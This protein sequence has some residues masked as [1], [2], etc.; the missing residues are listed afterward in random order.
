MTDFDQFEALLTAKAKV[1]GAAHE[2]QKEIGAEYQAKIASLYQEAFP[3]GRVRDFAK[4]VDKLRQQG[5]DL[6]AV[7]A[8]YDARTKTLGDAMIAEGDQLEAQLVAMAAD[9]D[10]PATP[11]LHLR[12]TAFHGT[13]R[14]QG[15]GA[16]RYTQADAQRHA[17]AAA[18][19]GL[20]AEVREVNKTTI[21][22]H[23]GNRDLL[24]FGVFTNTTDTG[25]EIVSRKPGLPLRE[26]LAA[27]WKAGT[28]PRVMNP[29][30]PHGLEERLGVSF[31]GDLIEPT[32][33]IGK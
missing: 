9:L 2:R 18:R 19:H 17:D 27:C 25:W 33:T 5:L 10:V 8:P 6:Q 1:Y 30:L 14:S 26:W 20:Q 22:G 32:P 12:Y 13:Y 23:W 21:D 16:P 31:F 15:Y 11:D 4:Q 7:V 3:K 28:N 29:F 24:D